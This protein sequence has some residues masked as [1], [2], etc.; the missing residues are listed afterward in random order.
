MAN[1][2]NVLIVNSD[3]NEG[4]MWSS[5]L[6]KSGANVI[7]ETQKLSAIV[8]VLVQEKLHM[9]VCSSNLIND[10]SANVLKLCIK[11][12]PRIKI[13][14]IGRVSYV[15]VLT[16]LTNVHIIQSFS[17]DIK[18]YYS[19]PA[20]PEIT[21]NDRAVSHK[22]SLLLNDNYMT[23][24][25]AAVFF[26]NTIENTPAYVVIGIFTHSRDGNIIDVLKTKA[27][28]IGFLYAIE[29]SPNECYVVLDKSPNPDFCFQT[30]NA[31]RQL[32]FKETDEMFSIGISR[33][34]YKASELYACR[35]EAARACIATHMF[36]QNNVIH[37]DCLDSNDVEYLYPSHK[38][39]RLIEATMDGDAQYAFRMLDEIFSVLRSCKNLRQSLINK[40]IL[41]I[42]V[43]LNI[44]AS[45]RVFA[46]EK[47]QLDSLS[48]KKLLAAKSIDEAYS[49]LKLGIQDFAGEMKAFTDVKKDALYHNL[50]DIRKQG[51]ITDIES[52]A[53]SLNTTIG[54]MNSAIVHNSD[55]NIFNFF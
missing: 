33:S 35:R 42:I 31:I 2:I 21:D 45:S 24:E 25:E 46:F 55:K 36:G 43:N 40:M 50:L 37:I 12:F 48:L 18:K 30:A 5:Q 17:A 15:S 23:Q 54:F 19:L 6:A 51:N 16:K 27:E 28:E 34:R 4:K 47:I 44:A 39:K 41:G 53:N 11:F 26:A 9:V 7:L 52:L 13:I 22:I 3:K 8:D 14:I 29:N 1:S 38:E 32:L 10:D 49:F 20:L